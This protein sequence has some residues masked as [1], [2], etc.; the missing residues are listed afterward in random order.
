ME[1]RFVEYFLVVGFRKTLKI[2]KEPNIQITGVRA[3][4][5]KDPEVCE[6]PLNPFAHVR[7]ETEIVDRFPR[8][9]SFTADKLKFFFSFSSCLFFFQEDHP[10][11]PLSSAHL[12]QFCLPTGLFLT[13]VYKMPM[14]YTFVWTEGTGRQL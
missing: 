6:D 9:R 12:E 1:H 7:F 2:K 10:D 13:H 5:F 14:F 8:V 3:D 4:V 11:A